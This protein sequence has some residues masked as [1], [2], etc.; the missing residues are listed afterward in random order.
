M[1][2]NKN[3]YNYVL[4]DTSVVSST[5]KFNENDFKVSMYAIKNICPGVF[6]FLQT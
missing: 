4:N 1:S 3:R 6:K 2:P 5:N